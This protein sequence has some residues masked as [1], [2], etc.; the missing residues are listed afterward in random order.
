MRF[1]KSESV[2]RV[3]DRFGDLGGTNTA[4]ALGKHYRGHDRVVIV[5]DEQAW[6]DA[7]GDVNSAVPQSVPV[8]TWN[9]AG[10]RAGHAPAAGN[11]FTFGGLTDTGFGMIGLIERGQRG[12][13]PF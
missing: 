6:F 5:T 1:R 8:Y 12:D 7:S 3:V 10:Y 9:V 13:W 2:L 11:R 4:A